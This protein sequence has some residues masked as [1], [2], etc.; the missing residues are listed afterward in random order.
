MATK[1][2]EHQNGMAGSR[3]RATAA[4]T[5]AAA[6]RASS[7]RRSRRPSFDGPG[8][9]RFLC[10]DHVREHN[11][12]YNFF[13][14]MS[15]DEISAR[16]IADRGVGAGEPAVRHVGAD[17]PPAWSDFADPLDAIGARFATRREAPVTSR[18]NRGERRALSMLGLGEDAD[19]SAV[20]R[21]YSRLVRRFHPDKNGG[22]RSHESRLGEVIEAYQMLRKARAFVLAP[23]LLRRPFLLGIE[24]LAVDAAST[25][26]INCGS[27]RSPCDSRTPALPATGTNSG[28]ANLRLPG[29]PGRSSPAPQR[30]GR[31]CPTCRE[32]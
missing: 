14:G 16:A 22:D 15:P 27:Y 5:P 6:S 29:R 25:A 11:S 19:R 9:W 31:S 1:S 17:P 21:S 13:D 4:R 10:L 20:R 24:R 23:A 18:F 3:A 2:G 12:R 26:S 32:T 8:S 28:F 30:C 7:R